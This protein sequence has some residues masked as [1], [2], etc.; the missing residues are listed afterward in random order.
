MN[1]MG[2]EE[3][4]QMS[5]LVKHIMSHSFEDHSSSASKI[6]NSAWR[7][8][9]LLGKPKPHNKQPLSCG[10]VGPE[11]L[12]QPSLSPWSCMAHVRHENIEFG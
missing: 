9:A 4:M 1:F 12:L 7:A 11:K 6:Y 10:E 5:S 2:I 8:G 3:V